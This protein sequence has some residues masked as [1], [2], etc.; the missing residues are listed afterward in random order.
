MT[1]L[2]P[3]ERE[4][5]D[6]GWIDYFGFVSDFQKR[7]LMAEL[8]EIRPVQSFPYAPYFD[9]TGIRRRYREWN[10]VYRVGRISRDDADKFSRDTWR[11]F[12]RVQVPTCLTKEVLVLGFGSN[13]AARVGPPPAHLNCKTWPPAGITAA[14]FYALLDTMIHKTG[15]SRESYCRV[16]VEA[17]AHGVVPIVERNYAFPELVVEGET[18]FMTNDSDEMAAIASY[19]AHHPEEHRRISSNGPCHLETLSDPDACWAGWNSV[20]R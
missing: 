17:Y 19:L 16:L 1:W 20:L 15:G 2:F 13:A 8:K 5:H 4:A 14:D 7:L 9:P 12:E 18:G 6:R 11:I 10:G 3:R